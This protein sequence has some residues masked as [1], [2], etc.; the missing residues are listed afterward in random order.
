MRWTGS[1]E[2]R[3]VLVD[4]RR[5]AR[6]A[7]QRPLHRQPLVGPDGRRARSGGAP[8]RGRGHARRVEPRS[9]SSSRRRSRRGAHRRRRRARGR[10]PRRGR[11]RRPDGGRRRRLPACRGARRASARRTSDRGRSTSSRRS[12]SSQGSP[13]LRANGQI[14]VAFGAGEGEAGLERKRRM[15]TDKGVD[16]VVYN[17]VSRDD[18]GFDALENEVVI[19]GRSGERRVAK[20]PKSRVA[21]EI[22][23]EVEALVRWLTGRAPSQSG[24]SGLGRGD[25]P[26]GR[27]P[28]PCRP[29]S[30]RDA[31]P[32]RALPRQRGAPDHRGLPG[33]GED[34]ARQG[35]RPLGRLLLLARAVHPGPAPVRRDRRQRL[36]PA[37]ERVRVPPRAGLRQPR[38]GRRDQPRAAEDPGRAPRVHAGEPGDDRRRQLRART[39]LHGDRHA[40]PDRVRGHVPAAGG[41]TRPVHDARLDR[42]SRAGGGGSH[43]GRADEPAAARRSRAGHRRDGDHTR[44]RTRRWPFTSRT[45]F[46]ATSS[47]SS[48]RPVRTRVSISAQARAPESRCSASPRPPRSR[49]AATT[50]CRTTSRLWRFPC[51]RTG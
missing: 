51:S 29:R 47:T 25:P 40:E 10:N 38:A 37:L 17:D 39:A 11:R 45:A 4:G 44:D 13:D 6:A 9:G 2:G 19:V 3:R 34:D 5:D 46:I 49:R 48:A 14:L 27:E 8:P 31:S 24:Q 23:D 12:T 32:L 26:R 35:D 50:C 33:S 22:L 36:Q 41:A 28:R 42:L 30:G 15:L 16:L 18:I 1:L 20:A 21:A 43:A 7:R